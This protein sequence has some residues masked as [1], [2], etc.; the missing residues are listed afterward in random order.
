MPGKVSIRWRKASATFVIYL[1]GRVLESGH[2]SEAKCEQILSD[3]YPNLYNRYFEN[4]FK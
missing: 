3:R 4:C 1:A 2:G